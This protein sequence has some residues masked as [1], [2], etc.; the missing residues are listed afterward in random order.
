LSD[1]R[2]PDEV[3]NKVLTAVLPII[4][5][6][7]SDVIKI[8]ATQMELEILENKFSFLASQFMEVKVE[9]KKSVEDLYLKNS[10]NLEKDVFSKE[11]DRIFDNIKDLF[12]KTGGK[13]DKEEFKREMFHLENNILEI[14]QTCV[15]RN[16]LFEDHKSGDANLKKDLYIQFGKSITIISVI[17]AIFLQTVFYLLNKLMPNILAIFA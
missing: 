16:K 10:S 13:I 6:L 2:L 3:S 7:V 14:K 11:L 15:L 12:V 9:L 5:D 8:Q 17:L 1:D 4:K